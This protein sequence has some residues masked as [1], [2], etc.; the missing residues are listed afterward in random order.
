[1]LF[2][3]NPKDLDP[4]YKMDLDFGD[5]FSRIQNPFYKERNIVRNLVFLS[6]IGLKVNG[7]TSREATLPLIF[8]SQLESTP[9]RK[10]SLPENPPF[11]SEK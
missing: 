3:N 8:A 4:S 9:K 2:L 10:N 5:C 11:V 6:A 7:Y 1:M